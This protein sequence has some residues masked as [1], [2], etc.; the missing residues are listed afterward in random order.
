MYAQGILAFF[1]FS[2]ISY[3]D[4]TFGLLFG[5]HHHNHHHHGGKNEFSIVIQVTWGINNCVICWLISVVLIWILYFAGHHSDHHN[6]GY[7]PSR[8]MDLH[9][10]AGY[11]TGKIWFLIF[12]YA[13]INLRSF[14][15]NVDS[16][17]LKVHTVDHPILQAAYRRIYNQAMEEKGDQPE[18]GLHKRRKDM[19]GTE[20]LWIRQAYALCMVDASDLQKLIRMRS[21]QGIYQF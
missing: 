5:N 16:R 21:N 8:P 13:Y 6:G 2:L 15:H 20:T 19:H 11:Y 17:F 18:L 12:Q 3:S 1:C 9:Y 7:Y 10:N 14:S 4:A